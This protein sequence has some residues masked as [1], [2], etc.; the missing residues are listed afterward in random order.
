VTGELSAARRALRNELREL[1]DRAKGQR[2]RTQA[3]AIANDRLP[4]HCAK[5]VPTT[6]GGWFETGTPAKDFLSLWTLVQVLLEW[7]EEPQPR[8]RW[9]PSETEG[10]RT[11]S[12]AHWKE[13]W[14]QARKAPSA[15][16][17]PSAATNSAEARLIELVDRLLEAGGGGTGHSPVD[18]VPAKDGELSAKADLLAAE[19]RIRLQRE[20]ERLRLRDPR[21][22]PVRWRPAPGIGNAPDC[23]EGVRNG[24]AETTDAPPIDLTGRLDEITAVHERTPSGWLMVLG[25]AGSGKTILTLYFALAR[26]KARPRAGTAPVPVIFSLGSWNPAT[27]LLRD[28]LV[29][30]LERDHPFLAESRPSGSSWAAAL[31]SAGYVLP[32]LD[33]FDEI[34]EG[35]RGP[36]LEKLN[37]STLPL[38]VTSRHAELAAAVAATRVVPS[39]TGI[40][41]T[42]LTLDDTANYLLRRDDTALHEGTDITSSAGWEYVLS[43]LRGHPD[44]PAGTNLAPVLTNPLMVTLARTLYASG[45]DPAELLDAE[46]FRT[47]EALEDHLLDS[48]VPTAYSRHPRRQPTTED[49]CWDLESAQHWLGYLATHLTELKTHD[50]AWWRLGTAM[51]LRSIMFVVGVT[52]GLASGIAA[53][54]SYGIE[55]W[56]EAG[57]AIGLS[58]AI[59]NALMAGIGVGLTFGLMHGFATNL[60]VGGPVF[61]PS[62]MRLRIHRRTKLRE[63]R[64]KL[65]R[66][67]LPRVGGGLAGGLLFG[68]LWVLGGGAYL[69]LLGCSGHEIVQM[70]EK[71]LELGVGLGAAIGLIAALGSGFETVIAREESIRPSD[72]L[73]A[74]RQTVRTQMLAVWLVI[75]CEYG[76]TFWLEYGGTV[77]GLV[78]GPTAGLIVAI[79]VGTMTAWGRWVVLARVWMPLTGRLPRNLNAFLDDAYERGVLRQVGAVYQF[80]HARLRDRLGETYRNRHSPVP[81]GGAPLSPSPASP[82]TARLNRE[83]SSSSPRPD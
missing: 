13:L 81:D 7:S 45:G 63:S 8:R 16:S 21:P 65:R 34:T 15:S 79:G 75:A 31:I 66:S 78:V 17:A 49:M 50:I 77:P 33:G 64:A 23:A 36:A 2:Q 55:V 9:S 19:V 18:D 61:E 46:K 83:L 82:P 69:A 32:I 37:T 51:K 56:L 58:K 76:I 59:V 27:T 48:L 70:S 74:N 20:E 35:L 52:V 28:W 73:N 22:L 72:L 25:R 5:L 29:G 1:E 6:V 54:I 67:F 53:G 30:Q 42:D 71:D 14:E 47:R 80:R 44:G 26:L 43:E 62:L 3:I 60:R 40:E 4:G 11:A 68:V 39:A 57:L 12:Q 10:R 38:L 41:L 24:P